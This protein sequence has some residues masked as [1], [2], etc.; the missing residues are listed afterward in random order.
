MAWLKN[1][2]YN[3]NNNNNNKGIYKALDLV[4]GLTIQSAHVRSFLHIQL[5]KYRTTGKI[6]RQEH[7]KHG[8]NLAVDNMLLMKGR[9]ELLVCE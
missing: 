1:S 5:K 4:R 9:E 7:M 8:E 3:N 2:R 6:Y